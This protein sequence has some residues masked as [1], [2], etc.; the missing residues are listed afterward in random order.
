MYKNKK[1]VAA[2]STVEKWSD[3]CGNHG[4]D[5]ST[6]IIFAKVFNNATG[7]YE[8]GS[9]TGQQ[10]GKKSRSNY[11]Y[12]NNGKVSM[13]E[14]YQLKK[15]ITRCGKCY[16]NDLEKTGKKALDIAKQQYELKTTANGKI[17]EDQK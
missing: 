15:W 7:K 10:N 3:I 4:C 16:L 9:F 12:M 11:G 6:D 5:E 8:V 17:A 13:N 1:E 2:I 14:Q